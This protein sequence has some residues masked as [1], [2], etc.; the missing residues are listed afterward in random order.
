MANK[1]LK[2]CAK[3]H[4]MNWI[5]LGRTGGNGAISEGDPSEAH[6][7]QCGGGTA[8][9]DPENMKNGCGRVIRVTLAA[10]DGEGMI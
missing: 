2:K 5:D 7:V 9:D 3:C 8:H 6:L 1:K 4:G 10:L